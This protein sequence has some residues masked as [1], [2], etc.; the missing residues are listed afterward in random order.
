MTDHFS[1]IPLRRFTQILLNQIEN[2]TFFGI[3]KELFYHSES[4]EL[5][6]IRFGQFLKTPV[7]VAAGPHSQLS[8]NII[9]AWLCGARYIELKTIQTLD[10]L[11]VSKPC[12]DM[13]EEGYN[14]EWSQEL[15][16]QESFDQ[17]LNAWI[18][19]HLLN[20]K[21]WGR[22]GNDG[23]IF[24]M[25]V[26]YNLEGI[27]KENVQWFLSR[28]RNCGEEKAIKIKELASVYPEILN[29]NIPDCISDNITL[30]TMHGCPPDE[31]EKIGHY[32][33]KEKK[34]HTI[35][36]LN[37]TLL[38]V[39]ELRYILNEKL[40]YQ[41][42][43]PEIA[44]EHDLTYPDAI[45]IINNLQKSATDAGV[46]FGLKLTNT[47]ESKNFRDALPSNEENMYMS[48]KALH[49]ISIQI[50]KKLRSDLLNCPGISFSAGADAFNISDIIACDLGPVTVCSDLLKPGGYGR[51]H[52]YI[53]NLQQ[54]I[55]AGHSKNLD[56]YIGHQEKNRLNSYA[57]SVLENP[58]YYRARKTPDIK[59]KQKLDDFDCIAAPCVNTRPAHQA[60]PEYM[61]DSSKGNFE[62]A[63]HTILKANALPGL[64]GYICDHA[65]QTACTR[66]N[67]DEVLA[68]REVKRYVSDAYPVKIREA[69]GTSK[70]VAIIGAGP[71]GLSC[72]FYLLKAGIKVDI[73]EEREM[74]GGMVHS[75]IPEFRMRKEVL[76]KDVKRIVDLG[77]RIQAG[78]KI[79][80]DGFSALLKSHDA[81]YIATG[82][83]AAKSLNIEGST[84]P[85]VID[86]LQFLTD[87]KS[88][89]I[90]IEN[91]TIVVIGGGNTAMDVAR[92]A[93]L[94]CGTNGKV[95]LVYRRGLNDMPANL[96]EVI[97]TL[98][99]GIHL[100]E[101][102]SPKKII[103]ENGLIKSLLCET[104]TYSGLDSEGRNMVIPVS[105]KEVM[106]NA[107]I[108]IPALGQN[109]TI[110]FVD[111]QQLQTISNSHITLIPKVYV[112]G[113]LK[114]GGATIIQAAAD[115]RNAAFEIIE[116]TIHQKM[117]LNGF[118]PAEPDYTALMIK[119]MQRQKSKLS[120]LTLVHGQESYQ[121]PRINT[122]EDAIAEAS[123]C[124]LCNKL[125]NICVSVCPNFANYSYFT[126]TK[127]ISLMKAVRID[128]EVQ[129]L[130]DKA[131]KLT[132]KPQVLNIGDFCNECGN[133]ATFCPTAGAPYKDKPK[134]YL[135]PSS[136]RDVE[137]GYL[138]SRLNDRGVIIR[139]EH[140]RIT[141]L[142]LI[143]DKYL[144]ETDEIFAS[145]N[146]TD[147]ALQE[148]I[149]RV[150]CVKEAYF[151]TAAH[152]KILLHGAISLYLKD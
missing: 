85:D 33:L 37:P 25:S 150:P 50:A 99:E 111:I 61:E 113:D 116:N 55:N 21:I 23:T 31:I 142:S 44:F 71:S 135:S 77:A 13:Q 7:G 36:K 147:F 102:L 41:T 89:K 19:I 117:S 118:H 38:G 144:Y 39:I 53:T 104:M 105:G 56:E 112:G 59:R 4:N 79:T 70:S 125:C 52:Q 30:S 101:M 148:V 96:E 134:F 103:V 2:G 67:Y 83:P 152:M 126:D 40:G 35:I 84:H 12:I 100:R 20:H 18:L 81:V 11:N 69:A 115:G 22:H 3:P 151:E 91:K 120:G 140:G 106:L 86:P 137:K 62:D 8:Q 107:D 124:L 128:E 143:H 94:H 97:E 87:A 28:M 72:A 54:A 146:K 95:K 90:N 136:F 132:Q 26:G 76:L 123:R 65:C 80:K 138:I 141:T 45:N 121:P 110:D 114:N 27:Q 51:L 119:R 64:T 82:A 58:D 74:A 60:I 129:I 29:L 47:L 130:P 48:G 139:R 98:S 75:V 149:F 10:E 109:R 57:N 49:P 34:L 42:P 131:F 108:I 66:M 73:F 15:R 9:G 16:I 24:N 17:Y 1:L 63:M 68:I 5:S 78:K 122:D 6:S 93:K 88:G 133:C 145:F 127:E 46:Y 92:T 14:C 32:L 43:V